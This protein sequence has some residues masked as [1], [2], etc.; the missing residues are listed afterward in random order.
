MAKLVVGVL[1][2]P[3]LCLGFCT[4]RVKPV[5]GWMMRH[6]CPI[7]KLAMH[8]PMRP[9]QY[10]SVAMSPSHIGTAVPV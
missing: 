8:P 6:D 9:V 10:S 3:A 4:A 2:S 5:H 7:A 1:A